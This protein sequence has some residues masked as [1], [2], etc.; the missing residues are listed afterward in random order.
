MTTDKKGLGGRI[1]DAWSAFLHEPAKPP[2]PG[3]LAYADP[4]HL[5]PMA[6]MT[7][8][9]PDALVT[10]K[11]LKIYSQMRI[12]EQVKIAMSFK[13]HAVYATGWTIKTPEGQPEDWE[14]SRFVEQQ[15]LQLPG[16][17]ERT[18]QGIMT[19][20][21]YGFSVSEKVFED[22]GDGEFNG[23]IGLK[24]IKSKNPEGFG[25]R[26]DEFGNV[27]GLE[28][29]C[30]D[31]VLPLE[32]F[33]VY[34]YNSDFQNPYG[35]SDLRA[36]Y[37]AWWHKDHAYKWL[38]MLLERFGVPP[39][40]GTYDPE[41]IQGSQLEA[42][43]T[44]FTRMQAATNVLIPAISGDEES[45]KLEFPEVAGQVS[46]VFMPAM[47][48]FDT[49]ISRAIL[50]PGLL[51]LTPEASS[52]SLAR[53]RKVFDVFLFVVE[54]LRKDLEE[55]IINEQI[56]K[57]LVDLN[58]VVEDY[59]RF[60]FLPLTDEIRIDILE[61]WGELVNVGAVMNTEADEDH[62]RA[63]MDFP[64]RED[65]DEVLPGAGPGE[66]QDD[67][68][69]DDDDD[70]DPDPDAPFRQNTQATRRVNFKAIERSLDR[71]ETMTLGKLKQLLT[72]ARD[73]MGGRLRRSGANHE[74][75]ARITHV[76]KLAAIKSTL[77]DHLLDRLKSGRNDVRKELPKLFADETGPNYVPQEA[78]TFLRDRSLVLASTI[79]ENLIKQ[80][81]Q[82]VSKSIE[83]GETGRQAEKRL[84][85]V[86]QPWVG[87]EVLRD[88][89]QLEPF[90]LEN[91]VRTET[92]AAYN[93]GRLLQARDKNVVDQMRGM[94]Y[95][96]IMDSRTTPVCQHLDGRVFKI[97]DPN[98]DRLKP[99]NHFQCRSVLVPV[100]T[101]DELDERDIVSP[102][103]AGRG[104]EL[105]NTG[106]V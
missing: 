49:D 21:D 23:K 74:S 61:K 89:Q 22:I 27:Q 55:D 60:E 93:Q 31:N 32:K 33:I 53:A 67:D 92:T 17:V 4:F 80:V 101:F 73:T 7:T 11:G 34:S 28:Q 68:D 79:D 70:A 69:D 76:P 15:M 88:A 37:R 44:I 84:F 40:F 58:Y 98:L 3:E 24:A 59:P 78:L 52:G 8:L 38:M 35:S 100:T 103:Q 66:D 83:L 12:D 39:L 105:A 104:V 46:T 90:R 10:R 57:Q 106:F 45:F 30:N 102:T 41:V 56:V 50:M 63:L 94:E 43:K 62:I 71:A 54:A 97:D 9:N 16:T 6:S 65:S 81:K 25:F 29:E 99:P 64:K 13:K 20:L 51:G 75:L 26:Q 1:A 19:A 77:R 96:S 87:S 95:A 48:R 42:L 82:A 14:V 36:A 72:E 47:D 85:D 91:I 18:L 86:F 5:I 2:P